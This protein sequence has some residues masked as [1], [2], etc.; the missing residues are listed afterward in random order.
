MYVLNHELEPKAVWRI[1]AITGPGSRRRF[2]D[3]EK[4]Q[5][6]DEALVLGAA[7]SAVARLKGLTP[8]QLFTWL[9]LAT[10]NRGCGH[11]TPGGG[12]FVPAS[13]AVV[14]LVTTSFDHS[15]TTVG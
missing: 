4:A 10:A 13:C 7:V 5:V 2:T 14:P 3:D 6:I 12:A 1:E 11:R 15:G 9:R 8:Q